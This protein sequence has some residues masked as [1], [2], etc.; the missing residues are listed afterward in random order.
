MSA[1]RWNL[2][3]QD[4]TQTNVID[5]NVHEMG[6]SIP[7]IIQKILMSRG[8]V[9]PEQI[10]EFFSS[11]GAAMH[12]PLSLPGMKAG[13][14]RLSEAIDRG[15]PVGIFGDF[16]VDGISGAALLAM[17]LEEMGATVVTHIP[18]RVHEGHGLNID[19]IR[20]L[21]FRKVGLVVTVDCGVT[22]IEEVG[23]AKDIGVDVIISDHHTPLGQLPPAVAII[24]PKL[25]GARY[26]FSE[27]SGSGL[28]Y[29]LVEGL[30][31]AHGLSVSSDLAGLAVLGTIADVAPLV[32]ENRTLVKLGLSALN[33]SS[34][35]GLQA[36][37]KRANLNQGTISAEDVAFMIAPR[38]N[39]AGR[40]DNAYMS[41]RLLTTHSIDEA[42]LLADKIE[43][44]NQER[45]EV[46]EKAFDHARNTVTSFTELPNILVIGEDWFI[47]GIAGLVASRLAEEFHRPAIVMCLD[48]DV[49]RA[50]AR[51]IPGFSIVGALDACGDMFIRYGGHQQ[52]AGFTMNKDNIVRLNDQMAE[53]GAEQLEVGMAQAVIDIDAQ[54]CPTALM[55]DNLPWIWEFEPCGYGNPHPT[56]LA[57]NLEIVSMMP[58]G[59]KG[60]HIK[61]RLKEGN[62]VWDS[63]AFRQATNPDI[64]AKMIDVVYNLQ[65]R[66]FRGRKTITLKIIDFK[67]SGL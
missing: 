32:D 43:A 36:L 48:G 25:P 12:D 45:R 62:F 26:P 14:R 46:A 2:K 18:H 29:K 66:D 49:V 4:P 40:L 60:E 54:L 42:N 6:T 57:K 31:S 61:F 8:M 64:N 67:K 28:A 7:P 30:F 37:Y 47:P 21:K 19:A 56:F 65:V 63:I 20:K 15:E 11:S 33:N 9:N 38:L 22:S 5:A 1:K 58:V 39:A 3:L 50:S 41:Y 51:S 17:A 35:P 34:N 55:K 44:L 10:E 23:Q 53:I 13:V 52:A 27:L 59:V 16:D 24:N